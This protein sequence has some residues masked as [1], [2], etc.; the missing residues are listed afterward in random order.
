MSNII[1]P[2]IE[3]TAEVKEI[4]SFIDK[5]IR[6]TTEQILET[7]YGFYA[8]KEAC[9]RES[10][11]FGETVEERYQINRTAASRWVKIGSKYQEL[12]QYRNSLPTS[13][14]TIYALITMPKK[15]LS[16]AMEQGYVHPAL[17]FE[18]AESLKQAFKADVKAKK[19]VKDSKIDSEK[20]PFEEENDENSELSQ[21]LADDL[22]ENPNSFD[23][24]TDSKD[25][26]EGDF[27][28][29][30]EKPKKKK[31]LSLDDALARL[32]I[33]LDDQ[34]I[35]AKKTGN[36]TDNELIEALVIIRHEG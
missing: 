35:L 32:E 8:L 18:E 34:F 10:I 1:M 19:E 25:I 29:V 3:S 36:Y 28:E 31:K 30:K 23:D 5:S 9:S 6:R 16:D 26:I 24:K 17:T 15:A 20:N 7:G 13:Y 21:L 4:L 11:N 2:D 33:N 14:S 27:E 12:M 22:D